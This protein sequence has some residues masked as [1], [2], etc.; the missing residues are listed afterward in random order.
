[1]SGNRRRALR[2]RQRSKASKSRVVVGLSRFGAVAVRRHNGREARAVE[3]R[4]G[5]SRVDFF[6]GCETRCGK[7]R[8]FGAVGFSCLRVVADGSGGHERKRSEPCSAPG[9]NTSGA[10]GAE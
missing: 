10:L 8:E 2:T 7:A 6:E 4:Y 1:M 9:C 3:T 5:C